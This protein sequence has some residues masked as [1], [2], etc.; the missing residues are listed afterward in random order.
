M[1]SG[2]AT[3]QSIVAHSRTIFVQVFFFAGLFELKRTKAETMSDNEGW[4][5]DGGVEAPTYLFS[6]SFVPPEKYFF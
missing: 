6:M 3:L 4:S 5:D 2:A 1:L